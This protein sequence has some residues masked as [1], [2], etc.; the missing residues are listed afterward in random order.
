MELEQFL[1]LLNKVGDNRIIG[2]I[3]DNSS[4]VYY[5]D[6]MLFDRNKHLDTE[7]QC[8]VVTDVDNNENVYTCYKPISVIQGVLVSDKPGEISKY[9]TRYIGG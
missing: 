3:M 4:R 9:N 6:K 5:R 7:T 1:A 8:I 2:F